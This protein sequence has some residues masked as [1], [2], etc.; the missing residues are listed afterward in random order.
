MK[1]FAA[2]IEI[3]YKTKVIDMEKINQQTIN[4]AKFK[5]DSLNLHEVKERVIKE[6]EWTTEE[7]D[8]A[9]K[10]YKTFLLI[11]F[12]Y[13]GEFFVPNTKIDAI[14]HQHILF[15]QQYAHDCEKIFGYYLHHTPDATELSDQDV[16]IKVESYE[17]TRTRFKSV[18]NLE[19]EKLDFRTDCSN[20]CGGGE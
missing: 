8:L 5:I 17:R 3:N 19:L 9:E 16:T 10:Q 6:K 12:L 11:I 2:V 20:C 4:R 1:R 18:S 15:T 14:W 7:V 13:P